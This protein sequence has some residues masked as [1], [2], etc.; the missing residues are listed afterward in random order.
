MRTLWTAVACCV[1]SLGT[2]STR[3]AAAQSRDLPATRV[4]SADYVSL[5][6]MDEP[7]L[8]PDGQS[9]AIRILNVD[10]R[11]QLATLDTADFSKVKVIATFS[12]SDVGSVR[13][14][15][16]K[17]L[18]YEVWS[19]HESAYESGAYVRFAV[20]SDGS[21]A[22]KL[23]WGGLRFSEDRAGMVAMGQFVRTLTDGSGDVVSANW[24]HTMKFGYGNHWL[25]ST[26]MRYDTRTGREKQLLV[27]G[28]VPHGVQDWIVDGQGRVRA[29]MSSENG[30]TAMFSFDEQ[31]NWVER[32]RFNTWGPSTTRFSPIKIAVDGKLYVAH[33]PQ[34][35]GSGEALFV[36]DVVTGKIAD[37]PVISA[38]GFDLDPVLIEDRRQHKVIGVRY[39]TD[40]E[41][42]AW[43]DDDMKA[44][45]ARLDKQL[46]GRIN[47][48]V[49]ASCG[50]SSKVLVTSYSDRQPSQYFIFDRQTLT[51]QQIGSARH[52]IDERQA[53]TTDFYRIKARDGLEIPVYVTKPR[54]NGPWPTVVLVH[55]GPFLRGWNWEWDGES[56]FL[57]ARGYLVVKPEFR[58]S[59]GYGDALR[60]AGYRQWGLKMQDDIA[61]AT[62][63]AAK[64]GLSDPERTC[65]AGASYGGYATLMGLVRYREL[66]RCGAAWSAVTDLTLMHD[67]YW[68]DMN[69]EYRENGLPYLV[70]DVEKDA[71]QF[72]ATSPLQQ[73]ARIDR[74]LLL[75]HGSLDSRV[76][77]DHATKL[78]RA[79]QA[80]HA[81]VEWIEYSDEA[82]GWF[83]PDTRIAFYDRMADFLD[84]NIGT[85]QTQTSAAAAR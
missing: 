53:A 45:Q 47:R 73:A 24:T 15:D 11:R 65:I 31:G 5:E 39:Q 72:A 29:G 25:D 17:R 3:W 78:L 69:D 22:M 84:R 35:A 59:D 18:I 30:Q 26:P 63:W 57:A 85:S 81:P 77:I 46:P 23:S 67:I 56:Q 19:Q 58:G 20:D 60:I 1:L 55:G 2:L 52:K 42:V 34:E 83:N 38:R 7:V 10:G 74:P 68:S 4:S 66:Y 43:F 48:L 37:V 6:D 54:G 12:N 75:A 27:T 51:I 21:N 50:C 32:V 14:I 36:A 76:P 33:S 44:V 13:W 28:R 16:D 82:H 8:S 40:A 79:L 62:R 64:Q 9:V 61:D 41:G 70:G 71:A 80:H 49:P